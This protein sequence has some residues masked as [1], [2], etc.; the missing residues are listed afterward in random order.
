MIVTRKISIGIKGM[1]EDKYY[2]FYHF[3]KAVGKHE[4]KN[5]TNS[6]DDNR[7]PILV[8]PATAKN[9]E[10]QTGKH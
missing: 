7:S 6:L 9:H 4:S 2:S 8:E 10:K 5:S 1:F 3:G